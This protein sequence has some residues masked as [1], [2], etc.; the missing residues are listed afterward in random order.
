MKN[1]SRGRVCGG[2][3][4]HMKNERWSARPAVTQVLYFS[5]AAARRSRYL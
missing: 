5:T 1:M 3:D 4:V 2:R